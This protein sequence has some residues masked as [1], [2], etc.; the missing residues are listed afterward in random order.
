M[1]K[2]EGDKVEWHEVMKKTIELALTSLSTIKVDLQIK[3]N[4]KPIY[5]NTDKAV[6]LAIAV[7][8]LVHNAIEHGFHQQKKGILIIEDQIQDK[9]L[10]IIISNSGEKLPQNFNE[11]NYDLGLQ[12]VKTLSEIELK[13]HFNIINEKEYVTAYIRCPIN[14][15][16]ERE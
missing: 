11:S 3:N 9:Q 12:I 1:A 2:Q 7:N 5:L 4:A 14:Q 8:E 16:E 10:H 15:W 6:P 13:G